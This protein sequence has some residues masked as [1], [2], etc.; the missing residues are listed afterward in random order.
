MINSSPQRV[1]ITGGSS[2]IGEALAYAF[3]QAGARLILSGRRAD[4]L[5]RVQN[6]CGGEQSAQVLPLDV[7]Q[8]A[9]LPDKA[10]AALQ[11]FGGIDILVNNAGVTQRSLVEDTELDVYRRLMEVNFFGAVALTKAVLPAMIENKSGHIVVISSLVGK[12]GTPLRSGYAAAKHA[13]HGFFDSLRAEV[14]RYGIKVLLVCPGYIR[15]DISLR[16]LRGDGSL[17]AKMDS[18]QARGMPVEE[19]AAQIMK[20][21]SHNKEEIYVGGRDKYVVYLK[22]FFP[23]VF[24]RMMAR[25]G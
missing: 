9:E 25:S 3:H 16:A 18:G 2:G 13:L 22:R 10:R 23:R 11:M 20:A 21:L 1:W 12:F 17:H 15:T 5:T 8:S 7:T 4:E 14:S 6:R 24:S 19:C